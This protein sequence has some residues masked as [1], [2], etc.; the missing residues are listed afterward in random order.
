MCS[1]MGGCTSCG[2]CSAKPRPARTDGMR[3]MTWNPAP[4]P[5]YG[6]L[7]G[8]PRNQELINTYWAPVGAGVSS[9]RQLGA[10][11]GGW[12]Q[13]EWSA[14]TPDQQTAVLKADTQTQSEIRASIQSGVT[15]AV[16]LIRAG[17]DAGQQQADRDRDLELARINANRDIQIARLK[18][19]NGQP[20]DTTTTET[21]EGTTASGSGGLLLVAAAGV[22]AFMFMGKKKKR[23]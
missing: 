4:S 10:I 9:E 23:S 2:S 22:A 8:S 6:T 16:A 13:A 5:F 21:K 15:A 18:A 1:G 3:G 19:E 20:I 12:T 7:D 11:P 17:I 14:L